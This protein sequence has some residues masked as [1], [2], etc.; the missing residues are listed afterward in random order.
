MFIIKEA[1]ASIHL[2]HI[3][4]N[5]SPAILF[6]GCALSVRVRPWRC[7]RLASRREAMPQALRDAIRVRVHQYK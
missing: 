3:S 1:I 5:K 7:R 2:R 4:I 6:L